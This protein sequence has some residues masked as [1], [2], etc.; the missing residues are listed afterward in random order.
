MSPNE[1]TVATMMMMRVHSLLYPRGII[2][3]VTLAKE[4][5][6]LSFTL[7]LTSLASSLLCP[8]ASSV[9]FMA[10][11]ATTVLSFLFFYCLLLN[12]LFSYI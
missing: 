10:L 1:R 9:F 3:L 11:L 5:L 7:S 8:A 2:G 6:S 4:V 12:F